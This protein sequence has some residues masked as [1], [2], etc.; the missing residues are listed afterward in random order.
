MT[1]ALLA[2]PK[3][4]IRKL[5]VIEDNEKY[6]EY[7]EVSSPKFSRQ[8]LLTM[9][10]SQPLKELDSRLEIVPRNGFAWDAYLFLEDTGLLDGVTPHDWKEGSK[11][12][13]YTGVKFILRTTFF[14][15]TSSSAFHISSSSSRHGRAIS[16]TAIA[17]YT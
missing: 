8:F 15:S 7:L 9:L 2:L 5:I 13:V 17:V 10:C 11:S 14:H 4:R 3:E 16:I 1:R 12:N 6:L